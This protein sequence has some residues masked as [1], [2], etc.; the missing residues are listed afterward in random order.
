MGEKSKC[1][2]GR[3]KRLRIMKVKV[4]NIFCYKKFPHLLNSPNCAFSFRRIL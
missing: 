4:E 3:D 2:T 1:E